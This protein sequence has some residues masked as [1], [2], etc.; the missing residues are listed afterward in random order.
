MYIWNLYWSSFETLPFRNDV[1]IFA[2]VFDNAFC[3]DKTGGKI[4]FYKWLSS[5]FQPDYFSKNAPLGKSPPYCRR[6]IL[7][8]HVFSRKI[9][10]K[11]RIS[12]YESDKYLFSSESL[13][14]GL[15]ALGDMLNI[16]RG[17]VRAWEEPWILKDLIK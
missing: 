1:Q 4:S 17:K 8:F 13:K 14:V 6:I 15:G 3:I 16:D 10:L 5:A 2:Q 7:I 12:I 9:N 11:Q